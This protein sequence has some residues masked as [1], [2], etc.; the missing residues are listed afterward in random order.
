MGTY[1]KSIIILMLVCGTS[2]QYT[3]H[4]EDSAESYIESYRDLAI[5][6]MYR[7]GIPASITLAQALHESNYGL[8]ALAT[9]ANNHFGIKCKS[10]WVG[11]T[12]YHKDDDYL[13]GRL[14]ESCFRSYES[15]IDSYVDHSYFLKT[16]SNYRH[17][18]SLSSK[19][20]KSW[21]YGLKEAGYAT[22]KRYAQKLINK[23]E[24]YG[25][26]QYDH[27]ENPLEK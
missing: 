25:L 23:I 3:S 15:T 26:D 18:F 5:V 6:E 13:R 9:N 1:Y 21:A 12:Y 22:D 19:D 8:S 17:L 24:K 20:Y 2:I 11:G 14:I 27:W 4:T 10:N 7:T 16:R